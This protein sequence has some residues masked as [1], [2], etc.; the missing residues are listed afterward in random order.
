[1]TNSWDRPKLTIPKTKGEWIWDVIGYFSFIGSIVLLVTVW[2]QLPEQVPAH[3]NGAGEVDRWGSKWELLILPGIGMFMLLL[4]QTLEAFPE[5]HNYPSR[6]NPSN[7]RQFYL[8]SRKVLNQVKNI[9]L[10]LFSIILLESI[11]GAL[12]WGL[13]LSKFFLPLTILGTGIPIVIGILK[14]RKIK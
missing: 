12:G 14:F 9:C 4:M 8:Q 5:T 10:L 2:H 13:G 1:M 7:A 3:Y 11:S 6:F